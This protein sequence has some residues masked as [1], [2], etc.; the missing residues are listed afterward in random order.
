MKT[1]PAAS[2]KPTNARILKIEEEGDP[3]KRR[4]KPKIRLQG[5]W[6]ER[7]GFRP[8]HRVS[9]THIAEGVIELRSEDSGIFDETGNPS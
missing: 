1:L 8:G 2:T 3:W 7:A 5:K 4:T 9:I 6:L